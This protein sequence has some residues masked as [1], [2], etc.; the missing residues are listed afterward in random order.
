MARSRFLTDQAR[1]LCAALLGLA[2]LF[3]TVG[4]AVAFFSQ[5]P[6][7]EEIAAGRMLFIHQFTP[8]DRLCGDGDGLGPVFNE[9]SCVAC[10]FLGG[11]GGAGPNENNVIS[12]EVFPTP[13]RPQLLA[14]GVHSCAIEDSLLESVDR[15]KQM[16]PPIPG[17][18]QIVNGCS[19]QASDFDPLVVEEINT[20]ALFGAGLIDRLPSASIIMHGAQRTLGKLARELEGDFSGTGLGRPRRTKSGRAGKFGWKGQFASLEEFVAAAC[21]MELGLTNP[22]AAQP[23]ALMHIEDRDAKLDMTR[24]Q[25]RELVSFVSSLPAPQQVMPTDPTLRQAV[26]RGEQVFVEI[27]CAECHVPDMGGIKGIYSDFHLYEVEDDEASSTYVEPEF[28]PRFTLP[29]DHARPQEWK[30]PPLWGVADSAPYFHD[31]RTPTLSAAIKR[32]GRDARFARDNFRDLK[33]P[34]Q[35]A[36]LAFLRSLRAPVVTPST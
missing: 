15:L 18:T 2:I 27:G 14:G 12:F 11:V 6:S 22:K 16:F 3:G 29:D 7:P 30:T 4:L 31:G 9:R 5:G 33:Q 35:F 10:H 24:R 23:V 13:E 36:L 34:D 17:A 1:V 28:S 19:V 26:Q 21:A 25:L 32:H 20:P 8:N